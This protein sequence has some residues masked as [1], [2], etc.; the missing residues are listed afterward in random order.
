LSIDGLS[1]PI[2]RKKSTEPMK[3]FASLTLFVILMGQLRVCAQTSWKGT[4]NNSWSTA[5]N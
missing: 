5:G 3:Q 2:V 4:V 1:Q